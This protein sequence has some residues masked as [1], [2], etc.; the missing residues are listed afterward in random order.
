MC[1]LESQSADPMIKQKLASALGRAWRIDRLWVRGWVV[2]GQ[3]LSVA[4]WLAR[5]T[6]FPAPSTPPPA[7]EAE[8]RPALIT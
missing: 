6:K 4:G 3:G 7:P 8:T 1:K 2:V 5:A